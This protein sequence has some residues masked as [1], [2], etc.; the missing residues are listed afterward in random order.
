MDV[1]EQSVV[2][3]LKGDPRFDERLIPAERVIFDPGAVKPGRLLGIDQPEASERALVAQVFLPACVAAVE[4]L[5]PLGP[6][7]VLQPAGKTW[8]P[9]TPALPPPPRPPPGGSPP[10]SARCPS[11]GTVPRRR[12]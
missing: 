7:P 2:H 3:H 1:V 4:G 10:R 12:R 5:P 8:G 11:T 6:P 9:R